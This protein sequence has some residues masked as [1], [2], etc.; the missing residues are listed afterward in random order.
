[1]RVMGDQ[2]RKEEERSLAPNPSITP[3]RSVRQTLIGWFSKVLKPKHRVTS[4]GR[5]PDSDL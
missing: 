2:G 1:M 5:S 3:P 4:L